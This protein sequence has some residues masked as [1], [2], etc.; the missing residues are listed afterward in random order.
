[1][2]SFGQADYR[3]K[4]LGHFIEEKVL[5][6]AKQRA[7]S[8]QKESGTISDKITFCQRALENIKRYEDL[9]LEAQALTEKIYKFIQSMNP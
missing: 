3:D 1:L 8:Y 2:N 4:P 7:G 9:S 5:S 6:G